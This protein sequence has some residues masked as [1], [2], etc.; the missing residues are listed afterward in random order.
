M[1]TL[2]NYEWCSEWCVEKDSE[3]KSKLTRKEKRA[4]SDIS[5]GQVFGFWEV[6]CCILTYHER[7]GIWSRNLDSSPLC[8]LD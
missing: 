8:S 5:H 6:M 7:Y 4:L 2:A 3:A 1:P